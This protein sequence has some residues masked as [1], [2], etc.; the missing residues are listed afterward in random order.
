[1]TEDERVQR[2]HQIENEFV[3]IVPRGGEAGAAYVAP[4]LFQK[5]R[6]RCHE[7]LSRVFGLMIFREDTR[8]L[9]PVEDEEAFQAFIKYAEEQGAELESSVAEACPPTSS[10]I[11]S[12]CVMAVAELYPECERAFY[13]KLETAAWPPP[14]V[15]IRHAGERGW[16]EAC[17][18]AKRVISRGENAKH[19]YFDEIVEKRV[20]SDGE[21]SE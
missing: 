6:P 21:K 13:L 17:R 11:G 8:F 9:V 20:I 16:A 5:G 7:D 3:A 12:A 2:A 19:D 4:V 10:L 18:F 15:V 1:M 14:N